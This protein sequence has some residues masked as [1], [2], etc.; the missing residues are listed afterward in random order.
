MVMGRFLGD[1]NADSYGDRAVA[2]VDGANYSW[3]G[4]LSSSTNFGD[5]GADISQI[6][7]FGIAGDVLLL[8]DILVPEP[9]TLTLLGLG[10][11]ALIRRKR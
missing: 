4:D 2:I 8:N 10:G 3:L 6:A 7:P 5:G 1:L 9:M 11:L